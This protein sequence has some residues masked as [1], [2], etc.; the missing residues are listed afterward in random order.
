MRSI[1]KHAT[2]DNGSMCKVLPIMFYGF[3]HAW[4]HGLKPDSIFYFNDLKSKLISCFN[5][6]ITAKKSIT[7]L[8]TIT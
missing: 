8:F 6:N 3:E 5:I 4:Y 1:S 7:E 2:Q